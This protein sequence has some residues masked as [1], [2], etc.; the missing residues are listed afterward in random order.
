MATSP[1]IDDQSG[2]EMLSRFA[3]LLSQLGEANENYLAALRLIAPEVEALGEPG[4]LL[5]EL[6]EAAQRPAE[7]D[8]P[9][10]IDAL[11]KDLA[12]P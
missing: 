8:T 9:A 10:A 5:F 11:V 3:P 1:P 7:W 6:M 4:R 2:A 12:Q